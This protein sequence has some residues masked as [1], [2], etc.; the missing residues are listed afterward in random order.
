M[1]AVTYTRYGAPEVLRLTEVERPIPGNRE[2]LI[3][4]VATTVSSAECGMRRGEPRWG[5]VIL[6]FNGPRR[7]MRVL[8]TE[9]AGVVEALGCDVTRF[10]A[11]DRVFGFTGFGLGANADYVRM[12]EHGSLALMPPN[13]SFEQ[14]AAAV[15]GATTAW[16]FLCEKAKLSAGQRVLINGA[17]GSIGAYAVQL[18]KH[19]GARVT[20][21]CGPRNVDL[22]QALGADRVIDYTAQDFTKGGERYDVIF[23]A[24]SK[25]SFRRC[26]AAL[27]GDGCYVATTGLPNAFLMAWTRLTRGPRVVTGMSVQKNDALAYLAPLIEAGELTMVID[28]TYP[29]EQIVA[30][31]R[32]VETGHKRGNV[33]VLVSPQPSPAP[34]MRTSGSHRPR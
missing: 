26:R 8:G 24:V 7:R 14:A 28:R 33:V 9:V 19:L 2:V 1:R 3:R 32:H 4:V 17:A 10:R 16:Y 5:R 13:I 21:V 30:A 15:D 11:G 34:A 27:A 23:D 31:H 29:L 12:P 22:V 20:G 6:G 25:S 18:A